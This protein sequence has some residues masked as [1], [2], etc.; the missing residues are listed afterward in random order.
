MSEETREARSDNNAPVKPAKGKRKLQMWEEDI[1]KQF[2][3]HGEAWAR[4]KKA[5]GV[6]TRGLKETKDLMNYANEVHDV[7]NR[8]GYEVLGDLFLDAIDPKNI[9]F[10]P[11]S[12]DLLLLKKML[13]NQGASASGPVWNNRKL[14]YEP[15]RS[16]NDAPS[17]WK[18]GNGTIPLIKFIEAHSTQRFYEDLVRE[19]WF[20]GEE[21]VNKT[22]FEFNDWAEAHGFKTKVM[23]PYRHARMDE[24][25][26]A[27]GLANGWLEEEEATVVK[28][29]KKIAEVLADK[30][31]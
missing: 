13:R 24:S 8:S 5:H 14:T 19:F 31:E 10:T 9:G 21:R 7:C 30:G 26:V 11:E 12:E 1:F 16:P 20:A 23:P 29:K 2:K 22:L 4:I 6:T 28:D 25:H 17:W 15:P 3:E 18:N 27:L